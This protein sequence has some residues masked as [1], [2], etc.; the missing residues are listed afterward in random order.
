MLAISIRQPWAWLIVNGYKDIENRAWKTAYR[1]PV[2]VH[3]GKT[4]AKKT[5]VAAALE[6][7]IKA[8]PEADH[9]EVFARMNRE[10]LYGGIVGSMEITDCIP[11]WDLRAENPSPWAFGPYCF[12]LENAK[13]L[14]FIEYPGQLKF[15]EY[16]PK[17]RKT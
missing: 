6:C 14:P 1:G 13:T 9:I 16:K 4:R 17:R 8:Y 15:F 3:A 5:E 12:V 11:L 2:L 10:L 7:F